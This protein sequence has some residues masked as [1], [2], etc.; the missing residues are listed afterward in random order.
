[1]PALLRSTT[2]GAI[3]FGLISVL[4]YSIWAFAPRIAGSE[5]GM[6]AAIALVF[7][8][9][10]GLAMSHLL[11]GTRRLHRFYAF[12]LPAFFSYA[13]LWSL[14][15]FIIKGRNSEWIG[16]AV[17]TLCFSIITWRSLG[18]RSGF[19]LG[20]V[21]LFALH[22]LGYFVGGQWMYGVLAAGIQG[23][24]KPHVAIIAKLGW[25]LF[26]GLGFGAGIGFALGWWQRSSR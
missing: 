8:A 20:A 3:G 21:V 16:A 13:L 24:S 7:L 25:G 14:A 4:A 17:G 9:G 26:Y 10:S 1:M 15:W 5:T 6:Y 2:L 22:T 11:H 19:W 18:K 23:L 12:F